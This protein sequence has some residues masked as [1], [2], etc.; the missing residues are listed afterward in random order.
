MWCGVGECCTP[1]GVEVV[2]RPG[3]GVLL[4]SVARQMPYVD[5]SIVHLSLLV[6]IVK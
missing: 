2:G 4:V 5:S 6:V 1:G 3:V